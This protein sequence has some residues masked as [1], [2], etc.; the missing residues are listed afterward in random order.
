MVLMM[1]LLACAT[2]CDVDEVEAHYDQAAPD[3]IE[4][5]GWCRF[6][7]SGNVACYDGNAAVIYF[8]DWRSLVCINEVCCAADVE[9]A[10]TCWSGTEL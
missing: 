1:L 4:E 7:P 2:E 10:V 5:P 6:T 3:V 8:G 9:G